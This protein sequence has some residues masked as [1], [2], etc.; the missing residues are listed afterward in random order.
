VIQIKCRT[1]F[2]IT[3]TGVTG[4]LNLAKLPLT[5]RTGRGITDADSWNRARNQQRNWEALTQLISLRTQVFE[6][7]EP[8]IEQDSWYFEFQTESEIFNDGADPVGVLKADA[9]G[10]PM[11]RELDN[12]PGIDPILVTSGARQ[13]IWFTAEAINNVLEN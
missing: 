13:N 6:L 1:L 2:D 11:L 4:H 3:A 12:S 7:V 10:I 5:D 8:V 9:H